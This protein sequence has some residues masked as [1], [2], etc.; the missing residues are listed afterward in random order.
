MTVPR[1][2][3]N[4]GAHYR[5]EGIRCKSCGEVSFP[6]RSS[7]PKCH[8]KDVEVVQLPR[9]GKVVSFSLLRSPPK[10]FE[11]Y[12]P[13]YVVVVELE[14]GVRVLGTLTDVFGEV[15]EG[16]EVEAVFRKISEDG[17]EGLIYYG[18]KFRPIT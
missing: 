15:K 2:W 9:K 17:E 1:Y 5:L 13:Y 16:M 4:I 6:P 14:N 3:R 18:T 11:A 12:V 8:S 10:G 7:C